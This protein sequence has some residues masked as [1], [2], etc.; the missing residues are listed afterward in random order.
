MEALIRRHAKLPRV[1]GSS[2]TV[3]ALALV[4]GAAACAPRPRMCVSSSECATTG[5]QAAACVAGRCQPSSPNVKPAVDASRRIVVHPVDMAYVRRGEGASEA[6][7]SMFALGKDSAILF[8]RFSVA[9]PSPANVVEAYVVL[10]REGA[11]D[12]D[13]AP[14]SLHATR[15]VEAWE[16]RSMSWA[17]Q[18][19]IVETR[20]PATLVEPGG[21][22]LV[23]LDVR[24]LVRQWSRHDPRDQGIAIVA[25]N[26]S[27]TGTAFALTAGAEARVASDVEPYLE[28]Y[29][30]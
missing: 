30:R 18:P 27:R 6:L 13:P 21:S 10:H 20:A 9:L 26:E 4:L 7:P 2:R 19:R 29:V 5:R 16:G 28:L 15:I 8:L 17:R 12:D 3:A 11:V 1:I 24:D 25:E 14:I 23:R 22:P